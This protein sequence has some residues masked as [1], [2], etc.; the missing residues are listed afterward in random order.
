M[1]EKLS[2][3]LLNSKWQLPNREFSGIKSENWEKT[4]VGIGFPGAA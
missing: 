2:E 4:L 1:S 3:T